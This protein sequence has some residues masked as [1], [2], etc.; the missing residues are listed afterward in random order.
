MKTLLI[1]RHGEAE[2]GIPNH[3]FERSL[4]KSGE[5]EAQAAGAEVRRRGIPLDLI[6]SSAALR[7]QQTAKRAAQTVGYDG[8]QLKNW[9]PCIY[10]GFLNTWKSWL[11]WTM[12]ARTFC[13]SAIIPTSKI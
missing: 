13:W 11:G 6:I 10:P 9:I 4:K 8:P 7:A 3:D 1:L 5:Q 12:R 2:Q